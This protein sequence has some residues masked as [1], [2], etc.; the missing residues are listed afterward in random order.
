ME[1]LATCETHRAFR[2]QKWFPTCFSM[3]EVSFERF[4]RC[5]LRGVF[6]VQRAR[7]NTQP[8]HRILSHP[9]LS[10]YPIL[11]YPILSHPVLCHP[12]PS[13]PIL[14]CPIVSH[15]IPSYPTPSYSIPSHPI[16]SHPILSSPILCYPILSHP[17][18][19]SQP[20]AEPDGQPNSKI[21]RALA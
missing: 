8:S 10:H 6:R 5:P 4:L 1:L 15:P 20:K 14:S 21:A 13:H 2:R 17:I 18:H 11:S 7:E 9:I 16:P 12:I 3:F 19:T